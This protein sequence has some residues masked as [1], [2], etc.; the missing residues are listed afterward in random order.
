MTRGWRRRGSTRPTRPAP[1]DRHRAQPPE[2]A[3]DGGRWRAAGR[4]S[5]A[6]SA[7]TRIARARSRPARRRRCAS[8]GSVSTRSS[9]SAIAADVE[10]VDQQRG[11]ASDLGHARHVRR[12]D[13]R[14][15]GHRLEH[16]QA[17]TLVQRWVSERRGARVERAQFVVARA[18]EEPRAGAAGSAHDRAVVPAARAHEREHVALAQRRRERAPGRHEPL[19]VLARLDGTDCEHVGPLELLGGRAPRPARRKRDQP[20]AG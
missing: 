7:P 15:R 4:A 9:A 16:G 8:A 20:P 1:E 17:E 2:R 5:R 14:A 12:D 3:P 18:A 19:E 11:V 6:P 10:R 13:R